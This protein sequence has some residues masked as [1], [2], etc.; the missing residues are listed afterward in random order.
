[1]SATRARRSLRPVVVCLFLFAFAACAPRPQPVLAQAAAQ[2]PAASPAEQVPSGSDAP[3]ASGRPERQLEADA[4][5]RYELLAPGSGTFRILYEVTAVDP[6][7][8]AYFNP[9]RKGSVASDEAIFDRA[10]G[11]PLRFD[12]VSGAEAKTGGLPDADLTTSYLR[13]HLPHAVPAEG[14]VRL[15]IDKTYTDAKSYYQEGDDRIVFDRPLGVRRNAVVLPAAY[16]VVG[17]NIP[18]QILTEPDGRISVS[19]M[20][21]GPGTAPLIV[22]ARRLGR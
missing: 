2:V 7:A 22:K 20:H 18:V 19:F 9:I 5:T 1:V 10:T 17:C 11:Q 6:G 14:G 4:Y 12:V 8:I 16:E 13:V 3:A 15:L 21:T